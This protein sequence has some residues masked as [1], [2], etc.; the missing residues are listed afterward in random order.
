ME[1]I[2]EQP[3]FQDLYLKAARKSDIWEALEAAGLA[4][5]EYPHEDLYIINVD[6]NPIGGFEW[7][8][9]GDYSIDLIGTIYKQTGETVLEDGTIMPEMSM[10]DGYHANL[11]G[12]FTEE[13]KSKLP[14]IEAPSTPVRV[15]A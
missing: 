1:D 13:Q 8:K 6:G 15:W 12:S 7:V 5:K 11:R 3:V 10:I 14:L 4:T 2:I 9:V